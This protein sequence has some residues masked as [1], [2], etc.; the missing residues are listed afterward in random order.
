V[1]SLL[2]VWKII[3]SSPDWVK[4]KTRKLVFAKH[5]VLRNKNKYRLARN[6][7]TMS[8]WNDSSTRVT[9]RRQDMHDRLMYFR[10]RLQ[11]ICPAISL[12]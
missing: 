9:S 4:S 1:L 8:L 7:D 6:L 11:V 10:N 5:A 2:P 3:G 12:D